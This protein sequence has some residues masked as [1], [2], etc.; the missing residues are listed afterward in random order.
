LPR[1]TVRD[2]ARRP[3][4]RQ[5]YEFGSFSLDPVERLLYRDG[6]VVPLTSKVFDILLVFVQNSGRTL[7]KEEVMRQVWAGLFIE[8]GNLTRNISTLR[9]ALGETPDER[10][11]IVTIPGRGYRFVAEVREIAVENGNTDSRAV[12]VT[13][14]VESVG[15]SDEEN[16]IAETRA[17]AGEKGQAAFALRISLLAL[18][19]LTHP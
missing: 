4:T 14:A 9:K 6:E 5:L 16:G 18:I 1:K 7:D 12:G 3:H 11:Y 8:E 19:A 13:R 10:R 2:Q 15:N 17:G